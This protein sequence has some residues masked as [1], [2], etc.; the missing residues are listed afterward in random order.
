MSE[1]FSWNYLIALIS[2]GGLSISPTIL[3]AEFRHKDVQHHKKNNNLT[4]PIYS[5]LGS[6]KHS[7]NYPKNVDPEIF[8]NPDFTKLSNSSKNEFLIEVFE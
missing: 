1:R 6:G 4:Y 7:F 5:S 8:F 2:F 3:Y